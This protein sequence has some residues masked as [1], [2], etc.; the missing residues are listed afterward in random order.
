MTKFRLH[1]ARWQQSSLTWIAAGA[2]LAAA[3]T[4]GVASYVQNGHDNTPVLQVSVPPPENNVF[5]APAF[6][7]AA[8]AF[9][10][11]LSPDGHYLLFLASGSDRVWRVWVRPLDGTAAK[12]LPGTENATRPFWSADSRSIAFFV[13]GKLKRVDIAGGPV[14]L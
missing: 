3:I 8:Q 11:A 5:G 6:P 12:L 9:S 7:S 13:D 4:L 14:H 1:L 10:F 2:F